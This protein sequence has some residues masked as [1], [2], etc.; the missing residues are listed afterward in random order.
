MSKSNFPSDAAFKQ[1]ASILR[2]DV[3]VIKAV[4]HV[5]AGPRGAF[6]EDGSPVILFERHKFYQHTKGKYRGYRIDGVSEGWGLICERDWG[7]YGPSSKQ[8]TRL[9]AAAALDRDAALKSA[10][11]GLF[12]ILGENYAAC[13]YLS[14]QKFINAMYRDVDDH[15]HAFVMFIEHDRRL[16]DAVRTKNWATFARIY[17]GPSYFKNAYDQ[18]MSSAYKKFANNV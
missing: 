10:S 6:N 7:G 18:K 2:C 14:V 1:A 4:A 12:Q 3:N 8:H 13:G 9:A 17:N 15:L 11:Y 5:E 16:L